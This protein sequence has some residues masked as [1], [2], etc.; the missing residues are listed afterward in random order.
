LDSVD[1]PNKGLVHPKTDELPPYQT[2]E[3]IERQVAAGGLTP[4]EIDALWDA[5]YLRPHE[6]AESLEHVR[7]HASPCLG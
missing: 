6:I 7:S 5:L 4:G 3:E 2:R 1:Y